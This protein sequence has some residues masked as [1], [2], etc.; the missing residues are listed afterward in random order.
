MEVRTDNIERSKPV[1]QNGDHADLFEELL[2]QYE[3]S[4]PQKGQILKGE[5]LR[6]EDNTVF[7]DVGAKRDAIVPH[8]EVEQFDEAFLD[9]MTRGTEVQVYVLR[10]PIGDDE[11]VVSLERGLEYLD[12][13]KAEEVQADDESLELGIVGY[14]KGGLVVDFGRLRGF[15]PNSHVPELKPIGDPIQ[16][17]NQKKKMVDSKL[18]VKIIEVDRD[19]RRL[20][21]SAKA[22]SG[23]LRRQQLEQLEKGQIVEGRVVHLTNY[24]A[25][26]NLGHVTGLLHISEIAWVH[27]NHPA[28]ALS[29]GDELKVMIKRVD[30]EKEKVSLSR[31]ELLPDP[32]QQFD[33]Q[34]Q[35]DDLIEG[36]ITSLVDFGAFARV[37]SGIE[38]LIHISEIDLFGDASPEDAL[39][40]DQT[41]LLKIV[42]IE[43]DQRRLGLSLRRVDA[44][45]QIAWMAARREEDEAEEEE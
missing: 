26:V 16:R 41:V 34:N 23:E 5:I 33:E 24:G 8:D 14:N 13:D 21:M 36:Q 2:D 43:P 17:T 11:L 32:W 10:T 31:K 38:G 6:V 18:T 25:F 22:A 3:Y 44:D 30:V 42:S 37:A 39:D 19:R 40:V 29:V 15:V 20:V 4:L 9:G 27:V 7:I 12:W 35:V 28:E 1:S 45:E